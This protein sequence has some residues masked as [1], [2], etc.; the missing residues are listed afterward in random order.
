MFTGTRGG[1]LN[2]EYLGKRFRMLVRAARLPGA[3]KHNFHSLRHTFGTLA[4]SR[5]VDIYRLKEVMGHARIET[6][7]RY[8]KLRPVTLAAE[9]ERAFG[10][11]LVPTEAPASGQNGSPETAAQK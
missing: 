9:I 3:A 1:P 4:V 7:M 11:G 6:T 8:A 5:G 2:A 10:G